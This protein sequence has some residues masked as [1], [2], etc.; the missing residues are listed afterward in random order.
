LDD[1]VMIAVL[2][3]VSGAECGVDIALFGR[4]KKGPLRPLRA[5]EEGAVAAVSEA[6]GRDSEPRYILPG[7]PAA[8]IRRLSR[9]A[10][11]AMSRCWPNRS[12]G[13]AS[14]GRTARRS[15]DGKGGAGPMH[16]ISAFAAEAMSVLG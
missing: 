12:R 8:R 4:A 2:A 1:I 14:Q 5:G 13:V 7:L 9:A 16:L 10:S 3:M 6:A 15:F 11:A